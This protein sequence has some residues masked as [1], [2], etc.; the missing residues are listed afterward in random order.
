[1]KREEVRA[2]IEEVGIIPAV[3]V[4]SAEDGHF[5]AAAVNRGG[6]PIAEITVTVPGA[7]DVIAR[8]RR[9]FP[10]MI[11][12]AGTVLDV[13]TAWRCLDAGSHFLT[14]PGLVLEVVEFAMK[15]DV[16]VFPGALTPSE[17]I[18]AWRAGADFVKVFPCSAVGGEKYIRTLKAPFPQVAL[19]ASGGVNQQTASNFILA[20]ATALGI[21]AEL[22]PPES[23]EVRHEDRIVE[24]AHRFIKMLKEARK[25]VE[26]GKKES[27]YSLGRHE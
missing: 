14:S 11:V 17:V 8:L 10:E 9:D 13:D 25:R 26:A 6:I 23:V 22:I 18:T 21:G 24:L 27:L 16:V 20:G 3:R 15:R 2:R 19:I 12:G 5:A 7:T 4:S 1:M